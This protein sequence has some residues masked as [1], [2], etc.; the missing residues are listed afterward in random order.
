MKRIGALFGLTLETHEEIRAKEVAAIERAEQ[1]RAARNASAHGMLVKQFPTPGV[2][3][4]DTD[5]HG[6]VVTQSPIQAVEMPEGV[7]DAIEAGRAF[8]DGKR[9]SSKKS[10]KKAKRAS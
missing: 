2:T 4:A 1:H 6:N 5:S 10:T 9:T 3:N 7:R 8:L